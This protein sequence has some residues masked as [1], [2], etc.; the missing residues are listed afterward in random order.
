MSS[1]KTLVNRNRRFANDFGAA[2]L[3]IVPKLRTVVLTC[4]DSRV[5]PAH[6]LGL[7]L[8]D[9]VV[10]RNNGGRVTPEFVE[11]IAALAFIVTKMDRGEPA[12]FELVIIQH[13]HCGAERFAN[14]N[15]QRA[16]KEQI[17]VD[18]SSVAITDHDQSLKD[19]VERLRNALEVPGH[20]IVSGFV[21]DVENGR[22]REVISPA[23]LRQGSN[24]HLN[25]NPK[26]TTP[27]L[28]CESLANE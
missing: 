6:I 15:V 26:P 17:G 8:G 14:Q 24:A 20:I 27:S 23:A 16:I 11:E 10:I 2:D 13:T 5:D 1:T 22:L 9:A 25:N 3:P 4:G 7:E 12:P 28:T 19:D 21:Y 18:V